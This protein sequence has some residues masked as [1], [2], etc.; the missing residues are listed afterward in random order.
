M[1]SSRAALANRSSR[2]RAARFLAAG[3]LALFTQAAAAH[4]FLDHASPR[5]GAVVHSA[6]SEVKLWFT[7][8]LEP[9]FST[10]RVVDG[11]G[12]QVDRKDKQMDP[13][14]P[15]AMQV[16]LPPLPP[17]TYRVYWRA[18]SADT[19]VTEGDFSFVVAP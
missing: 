15:S 13:K 4:A 9:A 18:L 2:R 14:D 17:G 16:S 10:L 3:L 11:D 19:H 12:K 6:P 8:K 5:V 7:E 1:T